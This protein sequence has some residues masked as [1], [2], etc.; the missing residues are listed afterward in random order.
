[1]EHLFATIREC[2]EV[3]RR[4]GYP[5]HISCETQVADCLHITGDLASHSLSYGSIENWHEYGHNDHKASIK[6]MKFSIRE[7]PFVINT[8]IFF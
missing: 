5:A 7:V 3:D 4:L 8:A 1:M 2:D 6:L